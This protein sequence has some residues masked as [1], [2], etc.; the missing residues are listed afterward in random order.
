MLVA[1]HAKKDA[2]V[3]QG[4][5]KGIF[6][7]KLDGAIKTFYQSLSGFAFFLPRLLNCFV[8]GMIFACPL[9]KGWGPET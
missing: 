2:N 6:S 1:P 3:S 9:E 8:F 7:R 5:A 4:L